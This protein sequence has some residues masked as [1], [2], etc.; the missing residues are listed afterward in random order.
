MKNFKCRYLVY[1]FMLSYA[2]VVAQ[3]TEV[4]NSNK[5]G[6]SESPYSVGTG[7]Y[8]FES[9]LFSS[10]NSGLLNVPSTNSLGFDLLFRTSFLFEKLELNS[11]ISFQRDKFE[12]PNTTTNTSS[13]SG[14]SRF[15]I[16]AKYL[17]YQPEYKDKNKE[18]RSWKRRMAFDKKR[19][20]PSVAIYAGVNTD[21]LS[22]AYKTEEITP[23]VGVLLQQNL[24]DQFNII[25]NVFYDQIGS[26]FDNYSFIITATYNYNLR[27][28]T[29]IENQT[30][31]LN[32]STDYNFAAG[33]AYL[34]SKDLQ[35]NASGRLLSQNT[36]SGYF[37]GL[38]V[39][40]RIDKHKDSFKELDDNGN[41]ITETP[42]SRYNNKKKGF[43]ARLFGIFKKKEKRGKS[44]KRV[45]RKRN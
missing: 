7:V 19:L 21:F 26:E 44:R 9:N 20:I 32:Q 14:I 24:T 38:G 5:P 8:Q 16:G 29:F 11:Q 18:V 6:F 10:Y 45:K 39:S 41:A 25:T 27:W 34:F 31:F 13:N 37:F 35:I 15:T 17:L 28:S 33:L 3:Y 2:S 4:I 30:I 23:K 40:Y 42:I 36:A 1:F 12:Y 22:D 43:F